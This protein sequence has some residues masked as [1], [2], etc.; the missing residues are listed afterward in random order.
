MAEEPAIKAVGLFGGGIAGS[1]YVCGA[2]IG[3]IAALSGVYS[4]GNLDEKEDPAMLQVG[5]TLVE[6]FEQ[7]TAQYGGIQCSDIA[8]VDWKDPASVQQYRAGPG[9]RRDICIEV[10][11]ETARALGEILDTESLPR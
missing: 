1:G 7:L 9:S 8:R 5:R 4:R 11:G 2:L 10:V 6:R 3:G